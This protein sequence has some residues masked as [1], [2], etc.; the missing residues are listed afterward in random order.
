MRTSHGRA[1]YEVVVTREENTRPDVA[2]RVGRNPSAA[3]TRVPG[4]ITSGFKTIGALSE[5]P[6]ELYEATDGAL[7]AFLPIVVP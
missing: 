3:K 7:A 1:R 6:L 5:G 2:Y 4:A